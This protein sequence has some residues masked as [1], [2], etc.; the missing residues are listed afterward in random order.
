M[1]NYVGLD[2]MGIASSNVQDSIFKAG[3]VFGIGEVVQSMGH[4]VEFECRYDDKSDRYQISYMEI[5]GIVIVRENKL[6]INGYVEL[7][8]K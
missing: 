2:T 6:D 3:V 4:K 5:D 7:M 8:E 1:D